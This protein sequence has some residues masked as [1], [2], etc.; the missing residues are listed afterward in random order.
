MFVYGSLQWKRIQFI[1]KLRMFIGCFS[2][3]WIYIFFLSDNSFLG[4]G[5]S[6][7]RFKKT[8]ASFVLVLSLLISPIFWEI[9][10]AAIN[11]VEGQNDPM[12]MT[13][14]LVLCRPLGFVALMG[15]TVVFL[16]SSPFSAL[17][18]N[19]EGAWNSLVVNPAEY[20]FNRQ[21]GDFD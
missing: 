16:V 1:E 9:G 11:N 7:G 18:G 13:L 12:V 20:T 2:E 19:I 14:D 3:W 15:G 8:I 21:L 5:E 4:K 10:T 17:G 6:M